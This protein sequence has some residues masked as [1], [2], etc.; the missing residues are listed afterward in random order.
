[1]RYILAIDQ[2]TQST[3]GM[4]F[5]EKG[6]LIARADCPHQQHIDERGWVEHDPEEI[7]Q[8]TIKICKRGFK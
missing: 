2:S 5:D 3:K 7:Y 4:L 1:M 6:H 8:C